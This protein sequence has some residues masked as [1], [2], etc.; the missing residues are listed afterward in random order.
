MKS[1]KL[2][3]LA[4]LL[5]L[6]AHTIFAETKD[7]DTKG[8]KEFGILTG[9]VTDDQGKALP[10]V[11][12]SIEGTILGTTTDYDGHFILKGVPAQS[13]NIK[14]Q[15]IG[16]KTQ[17]QSA[18]ISKGEKTSVD[19][20]LEEDLLGLD[21]VVVTG[22]RTVKNRKEA[23]VIVNTISPQLFQMTQSSTFGE[24][25]NFS[26]GLR[27]ENNCEN[28]GF[29][30]VRMNGMEGPYSQILINSRP[31]F[32]G[33]AGVY[34][35]ELIPS[36][37]IERVE[38]VRGG[39]SALYGS[40]AIAGTINVI[41]RD[42]VSRT[43]EAGVSSSIIGVGVKN[44]G[45]T[46]TDHSVSMNSSLVSSD[47]KTGLAL[48]GFV[49]NRKPYDANNDDFSE[50]AKMKNTTVGGRLYHRMGD[51]NK[52]SLDFFNIREDRRGGNRF[53]Y[54][55]HMADIA[56][57]LRHNITTGA[58]NYDQFFREKDLLSIYLS[59]QKVDRNSYYGANRSLADYGKTDDFTYTLGTQYNLHLEEAGDLNIGAEFVGSNL[60]DVKIGYPD[61]SNPSK[62]TFT[63]NVTVADQ[64][65]QTM[66][67]FLQYEIHWEKLTASA[68]IRF[69]NYKIID[70]LKNSPD[71]T[72]NVLT[73]RIT[74]KYDVQD[75]LQIRGSY[76]QGYRA[77][78]I[79]DEDLHIETSGARKILHKNDPNLK[80]ETSNSYMVSFDFNKS[81]GNTFINFL[82][83]GFYTQLDNAFSNDRSDP[84]AN[85]VVTFTRINATKGANIRGVNME[86]NIV[87]SQQFVFKSG[88]TLQKSKY[89]EPQADYENTSFLRTPNN[90]G[91]LMVNWNPVTDFGIALSGNYTGS[92]DVPYEGGQSFR[93]DAEKKLFDSHKDEKGE[94]G[95]VLRKSDSFFDLGIKLNYD[96]K[97]R[98]SKL[99][100]FGGV[101]NIFN[102]YQDDF[103]KGVD[104]DPAYIYGPMNPRTIYF[105][106]KIGNNLR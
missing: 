75:F 2:Y 47:Q 82:V 49:R 40:N 87:P 37:M 5:L 54:V 17:K 22:D 23:S 32:S 85:G 97:I 98:H 95:W 35:L 89:E 30:Q 65:L 61:L 51:R 29:S 56:E 10:F 44:G 70:G 19:F 50:L 59:G 6:V 63:D 41:L 106:I 24:G 69:E 66:G 33:L 14:V 88:F 45:N 36:N 68:G 64:K 12:I 60:K 25:L 104:R 67:A 55:E 78:Q 79:F 71:K 100:L 46:A 58:L 39:G 91:Y 27:M 31:I 8:N 18:K 73:P 99:R 11:N 90:Y 86:L 34:G 62:I 20:I 94:G 92:M 93:N 1:L 15:Y 28:C 4:G 48:F 38:V 77:P 103:D 43:Y 16:Y 72:G 84:D 76:S 52:V 80:Q 96:I 7:L 26:P 74:L 42:P 21:E 83:E 13:V 101:K 9:K 53:E 57:S 3:L 81:I 102:S 105:G